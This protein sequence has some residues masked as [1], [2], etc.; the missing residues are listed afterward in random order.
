MQSL[1]HRGLKALAVLEKE[2]EGKQYLVNNEFS[3]AD[4][5]VGYASPIPHFPRLSPISL[6]LSSPVA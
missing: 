4:I 3:A 2:L 1:L 6:V 5:S